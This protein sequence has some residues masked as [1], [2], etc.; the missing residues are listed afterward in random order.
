MQI[1]RE[2]NWEAFEQNEE[3]GLQRVC[4]CAPE[5]FLCSKCERNK[6]T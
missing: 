3:F 5:I 1:S 6:A 2:K 4:D